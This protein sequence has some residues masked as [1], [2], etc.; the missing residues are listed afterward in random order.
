M[1]VP[2]PHERPPLR[3]VLPISFSLFIFLSLLCVNP[4]L[5]KPPLSG[6]RHA[7]SPPPEPRRIITPP[8]A[9][10]GEA[11]APSKSSRSLPSMPVPPP[12]PP[13]P[14]SPRGA[15]STFFAFLT[16][17]PCVG[18]VL[19]RLG[20]AQQR[21]AVGVW[22][23]VIGKQRRQKEEGHSGG[24]AQAGLPLRLGLFERGEARLRVQQ[25]KA[26]RVQRC[27]RLPVPVPLCADGPRC[28]LPHRHP[29]RLHVVQ[30]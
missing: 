9:P 6:K 25:R 30:H 19:G 18:R 11:I 23:E 15:L 22:R 16:L 12:P 1:A 2:P 14:L 5:A 7:F 20:R 26:V 27:R 24:S 17:R 21:G 29:L 28:R 13:P 10:R 4:A 8:S 3:L